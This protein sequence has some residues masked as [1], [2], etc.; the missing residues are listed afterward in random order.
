MSSAKWQALQWA[1]NG[2]GAPSRSRTCDQ[3]L[4]KPLLYPTEL[5]VLESYVENNYLI[6]ASSGSASHCTLLLSLCSSPAQQ[7]VAGRSATYK[8]T[9]CKRLPHPTELWV[10]ESY[11]ENNSLIAASSGSASHCTLLLSL[12]SSPASQVA[13]RLPAHK[14]ALCKRLAHPTQLWVLKQARRD[15]T[16]I[17]ETRP[18][19]IRD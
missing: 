8:A 2:I 10:L 6:A 1:D 11:V 3:R 13:R 14:A 7:Q 9:L 19:R 12:C 17:V 4:R 15:S 16:G 18:L 5:W